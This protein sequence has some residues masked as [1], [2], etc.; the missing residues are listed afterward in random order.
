MKREMN[1]PLAVDP[2]SFF[3]SDDSGF[4]FVARRCRYSDGTIGAWRISAGHGQQ[5]GLSDCGTVIL[6]C[7]LVR[8]LIFIKD[9][10][11]ARRNTVGQLLPEE[12]HFVMALNGRGYAIAY[13]MN[14]R[15]NSWKTEGRSDWDASCDDFK[16]AC[17]IPPS[18]PT[19]SYMEGKWLDAIWE[20]AD[21]IGLFAADNEALDDMA[22]DGRKYGLDIRYVKESDKAR[23]E[24]SGQR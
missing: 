6:A 1:K 11:R 17:G 5:E 16:A 21:K 23:R 15:A 7:Q 20:A 8:R 19:S 22:E 2:K 12:S 3:Y 14:S 18:E 10:D 9:L 24:F 4:V 13:R